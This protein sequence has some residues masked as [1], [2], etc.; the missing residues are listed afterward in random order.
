MK[1]QLQCQG[2]NRRTVRPEHASQQHIEH[3]NHPQQNTTRCYGYIRTVKNAYEQLDEAHSLTRIQSWDGAKYEST[4]G[5]ISVSRHSWST[6]TLHSLRT[7]TTLHKITLM[8]KSLLREA[9]EQVARERLETFINDGVFHPKMKIEDVKR[10]Y[11]KS[12]GQPCGLPIKRLA[13]QNP[14]RR[15]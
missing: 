10:A 4:N 2:E 8:E 12:K 7:F 13:R 5:L 1:G 6:T 9:N 14:Q 15:R 3:P 11:T